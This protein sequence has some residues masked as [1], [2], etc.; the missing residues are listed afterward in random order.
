MRRVLIAAILAATAVPAF[1]GVNIIDGDTLKIDGV[2]IRVVE[3]DTP[4]TF[5]SRCE[6]EL[7]LGLAAKARLRQL[8]DSGPVDYEPIGA[9]RFGRTLAR[10]FAGGVNVGQALLAEGHALLYHPGADA[11]LARLRAWCGPNAQLGDSWARTGRTAARR[12][13][14]SVR[15]NAPAPVLSAPRLKGIVCVYPDDRDGRGRRCGKRAASLKPP[16]AGYGSTTP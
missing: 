16:G 6:H 15:E 9:D 13:T 5:R 11:K 10:V 14:T 4:E 7:V 1:A 12:A 2:T 8:V 3:I